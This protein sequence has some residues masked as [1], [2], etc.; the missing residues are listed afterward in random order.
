MLDSIKIKLQYWLPKLALT[1]LAG[2]GADKK[3]GWLTKLVVK[4]FARYYRVQMQEAQNPD[5]ASYAT[6]N[7]FFVRPLRDGARPIVAE[8]HVLAL[9]ADGAISQLGAIRDDQIF[10]AKGHN[11][12]LEALLA[13]N[14]L[15]A[16]PFRNG[17]FATT[18]LAPSD[19]HR[20]HMPCDGVLREMI[21]VPG[22]LFSVNPLTAANVPNLFAR[23]ERVICVFDTAFGPMVQ[24]LVGATIVGSI[25]TVWAGT[26][27]PPREGIIR[28]W[29]YPA[30]GMEGAIQLVKGEEMG[31]FKLGSTV[32]NLFTPGSVQFAPHLNNGTVTR[33][34]QAFAEA[35]AAPEATFEGN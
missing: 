7:E 30:E 5:L 11:Y 25:E 29:T 31:R 27:T 16:E 33:M 10:Q 6:F 4:A 34:G 13:G 23:N 14:Y 18:Y 35:A 17:L 21:Y 15:L 19:Y 3:A 1:R 22:D 2:W 12:T 24:I 28:R 32:I 9:P 20:V 8:P 26:V